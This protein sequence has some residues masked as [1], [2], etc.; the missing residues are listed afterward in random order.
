MQSHKTA[1][2]R[3][4]ERARA[5][6]VDDMLFVVSEGGITTAERTVLEGGQEDKVRDFRQAIEEEAGE[7]LTKEISEI[8]GREILTSCSQVMFSPD[9]M[10]DVYVLAPPADESDDSA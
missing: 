6:F 3:G 2:G 4:P 8:I 10:I 5:Y 7:A 9:R 1:V